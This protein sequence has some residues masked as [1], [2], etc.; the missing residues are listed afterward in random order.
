MMLTEDYKELEK[1]IAQIGTFEKSASGNVED[2][3]TKELQSAEKTDTT[4]AAPKTAAP[5]QDQP[6]KATEGANKESDIGQDDINTAINNISRA[7]EAEIGKEKLDMLNKAIVDLQIPQVNNAISAANFLKTYQSLLTKDLEIGQ[8]IRILANNVPQTQ[9]IQ[10]QRIVAV[11]ILKRII[12]ENV[13]I[14]QP[15]KV[16]GEP[17]QQTPEITSDNVAKASTDA[18]EILQNPQVTLAINDQI[19]ALEIPAITDVESVVKF[20]NDYISV[21]GKMKEIKQLITLLKNLSDYSKYP[22]IQPEK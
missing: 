3:I 11:K 15:P 7:T 20:V 13:Q 5:Q 19:R 14:L 21:I 8:L 9:S 10:E 4:P 18:S 6:A 22:K 12:L 1:L 17:L 16:V 2:K